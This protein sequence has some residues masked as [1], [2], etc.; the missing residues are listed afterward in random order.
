MYLGNSSQ[1]ITITRLLL[2]FRWFSPQFFV[3]CLSA[4]LHNSPRVGNRARM[5]EA[6][7]FLLGKSSLELMWAG[8]QSVYSLVNNYMQN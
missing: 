3:V 8:V 7:L 1:C 2:N 6:R 5:H 4:C